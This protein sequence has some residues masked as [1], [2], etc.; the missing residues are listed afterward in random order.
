MYMRVVRVKQV[1]F[2][3]LQGIVIQ[4]RWNNDKTKRQEIEQISFADVTVF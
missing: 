4:I 1:Y 2:W 3:L